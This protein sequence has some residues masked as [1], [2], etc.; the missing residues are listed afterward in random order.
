MPRV[1]RSPRAIPRVL[2]AELPSARDEGRFERFDGPVPRAI[3]RQDASDATAVIFADARE[4]LTSSQKLEAP[5]DAF[6][7]AQCGAAGE[8][9]LLSRCVSPRGKY[10]ALVFTR[11]YVRRRRARATQCA[12]CASPG[13]R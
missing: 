11:A 13:C 4:E 2:S 5:E 8:P 7:R 9:K 12:Q 10:R 3:A 6:D 1:P